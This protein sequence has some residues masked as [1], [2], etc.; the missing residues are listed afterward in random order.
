MSLIS[1]KGLQK[2]IFEEDKVL[3]NGPKAS[4]AEKLNQIKEKKRIKLKQSQTSKKEFTGFIDDE[5][6]PGNSGE[7][8]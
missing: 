3:M 1:D 8:N 4:L 6:D 7:D 5:K 2:S